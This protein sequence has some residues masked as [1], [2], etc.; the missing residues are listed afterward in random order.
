MSLLICSSKITN[1]ATLTTSKLSINLFSLRFKP[2]IEL[3]ML[4]FPGYVQA[5]TGIHG[6]EWLKNIVARLFVY[7]FII[8]A[9][10]LL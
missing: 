7:Y 6:A 5:Y 8:M 4:S 10:F 3:W 2:I 9:Q 1:G